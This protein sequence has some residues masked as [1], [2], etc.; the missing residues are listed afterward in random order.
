[1]TTV[2][3]AC[4]HNAGRSQ[5]AAAFFNRAADP[6]RARAISAGTQPAPRAHPEVVE[7]ML[8][9]GIDLRNV[10]PTFLSAE[11]AA[12][13]NVLVTMGCG[14]ECPFVAGVRRLDWELRDPKGA[15]RDVVRAV[16]A[17]IE[18][19]VLDLV[20]ESGWGREA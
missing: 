1:M 15:S 6:A 18:G 17:E 4:V 5:M 9:V 7:A 3:F 14:E 2:L 16:R 10:T 12:S 8:E 11:L 13:A 20:R 19:R